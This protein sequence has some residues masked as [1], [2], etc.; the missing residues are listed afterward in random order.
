MEGHARWYSVGILRARLGISTFNWFYVKFMINCRVLKN[1]VIV[2]QI[3]KPYFVEIWCFWHIVRLCGC[4]CRFF[5]LDC[6]SCG[7]YRYLYGLWRYCCLLIVWHH[8]GHVSLFPVFHPS[9]IQHSSLSRL[10]WP[11]LLLLE[12]LRFLSL[13]LDRLFKNV[14]HYCLISVRVIHPWDQ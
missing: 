7:L 1:L 13:P 14:L 3:V 5:P 8:T 9:V 10:S 11:I 4:V 6:C 2:F 12:V